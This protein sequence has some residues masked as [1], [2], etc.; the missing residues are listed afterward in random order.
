MSNNQLM[1]GL[2]NKTRQIVDPSAFGPI[3]LVVIQPTSFCNLDCDY[4]Y[5]PNRDQKNRLPLALVEPIFRSILTSPFF[6]SDFT[7]CWH[8]GEPLAV[9]ISYYQKIFAAAEVANDKYNQRGFQFHYSYQTN[10]TLITQAWCDFFK[11]HSV[12]VGVS[13]DGPAFLHDQHRK[14]RQGKGS[15]E[16]TMKGLR[17]L[18]ENDIPHSIIAV[19]TQD[20]LDYP[21]EIFNFFLEN[22]I[23]EVGFNFEEKEGINQHSSLDDPVHEQKFRQFIQRIWELSRQ[24]SENFYLREFEVLSNLIYSQ[25]RLLHTEMNNPFEIVNFDAKGNFSTFDPE[26]LSITTPPYGSFILGNVITDTLE[27]SCHTEKFRQIYWDIN[28]GF[29]DCRKTCDYFGMCGGGSGSNKYWENGT[30]NSTETRACRYRIQLLTD[31]VVELLE[32]SLNLV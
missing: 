29:R 3:S 8:A 11:Q 16:M 26:L 20:S 6:R 1:S 15:Y 12:Q 23:R 2:S 14:N 32:K 19:I 7:V 31:I 28:Q 25:E 9:P 17:L 24:N 4:C 18:Q 13:L 30:F 5:L 27:S 21:D 22:R 10:A